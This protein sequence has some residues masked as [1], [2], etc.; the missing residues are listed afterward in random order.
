MR[1]LGEFR[2]EAEPLSESDGQPQL[3]FTENETNCSARLRQPENYIAYVKD[4]FHD[5]V[6]HG[7]TAA[8][9]PADVGTKAARATTCRQCR[10]GE[11][12]RPSGCACS[13]DGRGAAAS[14]SART[15][16]ETFAQ[17]HRRGRRVLRRR[18]SPRPCRRTTSGDRPAGVRRAAVEQAV[19]PLRRARTGSK[20]DPTQPA[21]PASRWHGPQPRLAAPVQPRRRLHARQVGVPVVRRWDLAFHM[22]TVR[23][24][25]SRLRQGA[26]GPAAARVVHAPQRADA[27]VRVRASATSTRRSTPGPA[28]ASTR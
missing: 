22:I 15:S 3:L 20:G 2:F 25:R 13:T 19:L 11:S 6:I 17:R 10:R 23:H 8:V 9:N 4:A 28:G 18:G 16:S 26:T 1:R 12:R 5:Y 21:P 14:R 24:D 27:G 7:E